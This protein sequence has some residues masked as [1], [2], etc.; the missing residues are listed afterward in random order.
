MF[1]E[2]VMAMAERSQNSLTAEEGDY[3]DPET[4]LLMCG[5]CRTPRQCRVKGMD[6]TPT[7]LCKCRKEEEA[8][9]EE[10]ERES[11]R[12]RRAE[13]LKDE[14]F[15][16][17]RLRAMTFEADSEPAREESVIC[18]RY[19]DEFAEN[20]KRG[21][22]L[23]LS[24]PVGTGKSFLAACVCNRVTD[25]CR[26]AL[27]T[28]LSDIAPLAVSVNAF[29]RE[30]AKDILGRYALI[31]FDDFGAERASDYMKE[32]IQR[33][34]SM[35]YDAGKPM[36]V[37]T[38]LAAEDMKGRDL[39]EQRLYSRLCE[40]CEFV[41]VSGGDRRRRAAMN[42][43]SPLEPPANRFAVRGEGGGA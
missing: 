34:V 32:G 12:R 36:I 39:K 14:C 23:I 1:K 13:E 35:R 29:E 25:Q 28:N 43:A 2:L 37:T 27:F 21:R 5:K 6:F 18:R 22:G 24:G 26:T 9:R 15:S 17:K 42:C 8:K 20:Y 40:T 19:A 7:V 10:R 41:K 38:N 11:E 33:A 30:R 3:I 31:V 4:G 16:S